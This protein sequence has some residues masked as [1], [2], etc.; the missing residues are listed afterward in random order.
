LPV[1]QGFFALH[2]GGTAWHAQP[3]QVS[4]E[5]Q[6]AFAKQAH[7]HCP[8]MHS[9]PVIVQSAGVVQRPPPG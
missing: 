2:S 3:S 6:S 9:A 5:A 8:E 1:E 4:P 7:R